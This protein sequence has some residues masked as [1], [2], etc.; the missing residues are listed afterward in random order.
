MKTAN[1]VFSIF[2]G[3]VYLIPA[4]LISL[5]LFVSWHGTIS[6]WQKMLYFEEHKTLFYLYCLLLIISAISLAVL[7]IFYFIFLLLKRKIRQLWKYIAVIIWASINYILFTFIPP[8][9]YARPMFIFLQS[10]INLP[11]SL[12][13]PNILERIL[14]WIP[15]RFGLGIGS[16]LLIAASV[17]N[18]V[19]ERN[20]PVTAVTSPFDKGD[21]G[22]QK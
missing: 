17:W 18:M 3:A 1:K 22:L 7:P 16:V 14:L 11:G 13:Y 2:A 8:L 5:A 9:T 15:S 20:P 10:Y 12:L 21:K 6:C 4:V 19:V